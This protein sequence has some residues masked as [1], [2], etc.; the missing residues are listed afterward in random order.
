PKNKTGD[1]PDGDPEK[2]ANP[3]DAKDG[4]ETPN[5]TD[6]AKPDETPEERARRILGENADLEKGPMRPGRIEYNNPE[7]DW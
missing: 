7:K 5:D 3:G 1:K 4:E 2:N 6:A